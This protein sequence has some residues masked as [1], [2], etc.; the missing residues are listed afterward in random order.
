MSD[1][2]TEAEEEEKKL[3]ITADTTHVS[4]ESAKFKVERF[5]FVLIL[6]ENPQELLHGGPQT[7]YKIQ[8][9]R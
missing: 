3:A 8:D 4:K 7:I 6:Q 9:A 2:C 1:C 5:D